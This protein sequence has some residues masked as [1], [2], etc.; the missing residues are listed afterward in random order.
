MKFCAM[1]RTLR[2]GRDMWSRVSSKSCASRPA[3]T[4]TNFL[5]PTTLFPKNLG[6][7][8]ANASSLPLKSRERLSLRGGREGKDHGAGFLALKIKELGLHFCGSHW[9]P[10]QE[11]QLCLLRIL[12]LGPGF[13][14][15]SLFTTSVSKGNLQL[16]LPRLVRDIFTSSCYPTF[17]S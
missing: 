3:V 12:V 1:V 8:R 11:E 7:G 17:W 16:V 13:N 4:Y 5:R 14:N 10:R 15:N 9:E 6:A 2:G